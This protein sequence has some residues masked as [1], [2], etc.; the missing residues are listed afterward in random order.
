M[1]PALVIVSGEW[2]WIGLPSNRM[3]PSVTSPFS[4]LR[5]PDMAFRVVVLP[6]P[7]L[8]SSETTCPGLDGERDPLEDLDHVGID[9]AD[10]VDH[11]QFIFSHIYKS[12]LSLTLYP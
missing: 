2:L 1:I 10:I 11:K 5:S 3:L 12:F 8:P 9:D 7:L 6:A 4:G